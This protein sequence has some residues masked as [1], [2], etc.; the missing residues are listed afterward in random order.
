MLMSTNL[1]VVN[2]PVALGAITGSGVVLEVGYA[3][4]VVVEVNTFEPGVGT[5]G[6]AGPQGPAGPAGP[7]GPQGLQG[8]Q[9]PAGPTGPQGPTGPTGPQGPAGLTG[10]EG[11]QGPAG[12][13]GPAG[14]T[15]AAGPQGPSG[16]A[17]P[18][19]PAGPTDPMVQL[20][21]FALVDH[22]ITD[23]NFNGVNSGAG[24]VFINNANIPANG[25]G[26]SGVFGAQVDASPNFAGWLWGK[27]GYTGTLRSANGTIRAGTVV[28]FIGLPSSTNALGATIGLF[29]S[30]NFANNNGV[31]FGLANSG[32]DQVWTCVSR[33]A[34]VTT[35]VTT[36]VVAAEN[37]DYVLGIVFSAGQAL[38]YINGNLVGTITTNLP[39]S[40]EA[41]LYGFRLTKVSGSTRVTG[42]SDWTRIDQVL[43]TPYASPFP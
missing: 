17:G 26:G 28:R 39:T 13:E 34:L 16:P 42:Y 43:T 40:T 19:G 6:P 7:Q 36:A 35:T 15:G 33:Q 38:F 27:S 5:P 9:G 29:G 8:V 2:T 21:N 31:W 12:P 41:L 11:P 24:G 4:D 25:S 18:Q 22:H 32:A 3:P 20:N 37:T 1:T 10:P 23:A 30:T 14:P